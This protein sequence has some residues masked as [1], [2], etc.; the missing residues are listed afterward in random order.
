MDETKSNARQVTTTVI[1]TICTT[2]RDKDEYVI[3]SSVT[4]TNTSRPQYAIQLYAKQIMYKT[5]T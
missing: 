3:H 5:C 4:V 2:L 1:D